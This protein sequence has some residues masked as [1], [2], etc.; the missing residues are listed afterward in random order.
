M[1]TDSANKEVGIAALYLSLNGGNAG[2]ALTNVPAAVDVP[3]GARLGVAVRSH[4]R[5]VEADDG[6]AGLQVRLVAHA[7]D[8]NDDR[9]GL[10]ARGA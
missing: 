5:V 3:E 6:D 1:K 9:G 8:V 2:K 7:A 4:A 10:G